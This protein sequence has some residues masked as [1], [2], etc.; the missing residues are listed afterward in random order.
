MASL[1]ARAEFAFTSDLNARL[2]RGPTRTKGIH[3]YVPVNPRTFGPFLMLGQ[4]VKPG[5]YVKR[6][7]MTDN[8]PTV[9]TLLG[10]TLKT[11]SSEVLESLIDLE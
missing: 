1:N 7:R 3:G 5:A 6:A 8:A 2:L 11:E 4:G 10:L 9:A